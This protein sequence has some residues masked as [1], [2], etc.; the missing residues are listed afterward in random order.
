MPFKGQLNSTESLTDVE[1]TQKTQKNKSGSFA[2]CENSRN[3]KRCPEQKEKSSLTWPC[4]TLTT[5]KS[6]MKCAASSFPNNPSV[7]RGKL[8]RNSSLEIL[9]LRFFCSILILDS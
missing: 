5:R 4:L 2:F 9:L 8:G 6:R 1:T 7:K 3:S